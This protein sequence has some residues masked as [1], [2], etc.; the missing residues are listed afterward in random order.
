M[1]A[2]VA[3]GH[4]LIRAQVLS[5]FR[6]RELVI[7]HALIAWYGTERRVATLCEVARYLRDS[8]S[9][10]T[11]AKRATAASSAGII[12]VGRTFSIHPNRSIDLLQLKQFAGDGRCRVVPGREFEVLG[13]VQGLWR[14]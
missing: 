10:L 2:Y 4:Y 8:A 13:L 12:H 9:S 3:R 11:R 1:T 5:R 6:R 14:T 7:A